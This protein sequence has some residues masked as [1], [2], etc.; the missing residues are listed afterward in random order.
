MCECVNVSVCVF[1]V[2]LCVRL[3]VCVYVCVCVCVCLDVY[4]CA[5]MCVS[6]TVCLCPYSEN[7]NVR[8]RKFEN[9]IEL[10]R[11]EKRFLKIC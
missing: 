1:C 6:V 7:A 4:V 10:N 2:S 9:N 3:W 11:I 5:S 8:F